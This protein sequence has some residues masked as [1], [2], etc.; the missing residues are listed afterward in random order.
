MAGAIAEHKDAGRPVFLVLITDGRPGQRMRRLLNGEQRCSWH[1]ARHDFGVSVDQMIWART[2]EFMESARVLDVDRVFTAGLGG[3]PDTKAYDDFEG[4]IGLV[5]DL[6]VSME[7][8]YPG[9]SHKL[10]SGYL[11]ADEAGRNPTHV[12]CWEAARRL[13]SEIT[14]F[15]FYRVY[16]YLKPRDERRASWRRQLTSTWL[17]RKRAALDAYK[18]FE[19]TERRYGFGYHSV[20]DLIDAAYDDDGEYVDLLD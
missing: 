5:C 8:R 7:G 3:V 15:R 9:S 13:R 4:F 14:D 12:A 16:E 2:V 1:D 11:E 20:P 6:I 10:V 19:P 17:T 18:R